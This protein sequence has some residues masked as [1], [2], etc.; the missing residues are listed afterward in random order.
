MHK[1][2][3]LTLLCGAIASAQ[4]TYSREVSRIMQQKCQMCHRPGDVAPFPLLTYDDVMAQL[5]GVRANVDARLMPPWKPIAGHGDF[6]NNL[7]LTDDER[8]T[9]LDWVDAGAPLGDP[10]DMPAPQVLPDEWRLGQPDLMVSMPVAYVPVA[11]DDRPDRY[12]CFILP[13]VVDQ[14]RWVRA[15]DI[16][17]GL[18]TV[19]H[20]VILY[21]TDDPIQIA[22]AQ[23]LENEDSDP[24][25]DCWGGPRIN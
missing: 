17:P 15:V 12:R 20:H 10:G 11:R 5:R 7:S 6:K 4:P 23:K 16:V 13:N 21:I 24:G 9:I 18:R 25:Y 2:L 14:D 8:Q 19:V 3:L 1:L 22:L